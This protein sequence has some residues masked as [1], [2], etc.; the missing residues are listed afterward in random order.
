MKMIRNIALFLSVL[1]VAGPLVGQEMSV[2]SFEL[3]EK[4]LN[5]KVNPV[6]DLNGEECAL[7]RVQIAL[8]G[9]V[10]EGMVMGQPKEMTGEYFVYMP[11]M[12]R[13]LRIKADGYLPLEYTFPFRLEKLRTYS[14]RILLPGVPDAGELPRPT[15]QYL[16]L[17]VQPK[18]A[19]V[20]IDNMPRALDANGTLFLELP[21]GEHTYQ[22]SASGCRSRQGTFA[23]IDT[24][25]TMLDISLA[26]ATG[27]VNVQTTP[28]EGV[29]VL[30]DGNS[31]GTAPCRLQLSGGEHQLQL[32]KA[33]YLAYNQ[34]VRVVDGETINVQA[35]LQVNSSQVTLKA[36]N[37]KAEIWVSGQKMGVGTWTGPLDAGT[38]SVESRLEGY[39]NRID[40]IAVK[41]TG[42]RSFLLS[43]QQP[44]Y[45]VLKVTSSPMGAD[46]YL[47]GKKIGQTPYLDS[48]ILVGRHAV[49][50]V[51]TGCRTEGR[52]VELKKGTPCDVELKLTSGKTILP[53]EQ[54]PLAAAVTA[55]ATTTAGTT[56][57]ASATGEVYQVGDYYAKGDL[58]GIVFWVDGSGEHGKIISMVEQALSWDNPGSVRVSGATDLKDGAQNQQK[59]AALTM[60]AAPAFAYAKSMGDGWYLPAKE[61]LAQLQ[62]SRVKVNAALKKMGQNFLKAWYW[63][64]SEVDNDQAWC[65]DMIGGVSYKRP[66]EV[67]L[68]V[69]PI[70]KF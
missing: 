57:S 32:L 9:V 61:E 4:D 44:I 12:A 46:I 5:A 63:S 51:K 45:G 10:F 26:P 2:K 20:I 7:V 53:T 21:L 31:V 33:G 70:A 62:R 35:T 19:M 47:D 28:A 18:G 43:E 69:R 8:S 6:F 67:S 23:L 36:A 58:R 30:V 54:N 50:V 1:L 49:A 55:P 66:K 3:R 29:Q 52:M 56:S 27:W 40:V 64:S 42:E 25:K 68:P 60:P 38:Y 17:N 15:A 34:S 39:E 16:V 41:T 37:P 11:T 24:E 48:R 65:I 22:I 14:M 13:S 59:G